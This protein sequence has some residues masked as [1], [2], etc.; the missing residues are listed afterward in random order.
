MEK[1]CAVSQPT[2]TWQM[3][4]PL[5]VRADLIILPDEVPPDVVPVPPDKPPKKA[6]EKKIRKG[7]WESFILGLGK[8]GRRKGGKS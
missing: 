1:V 8:T 2:T 4:A 6:P 7:F 5:K 3:I